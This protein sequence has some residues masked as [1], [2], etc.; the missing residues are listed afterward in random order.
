MNEIGRQQY[1]K[2]AVIVLILVYIGL[3]VAS[4]LVTKLRY[5]PDEPA[6]F[7][8][9]REIGEHLRLPGLSHEET[10]EISLH[11][12]HEAHQPPLYY[13]L[14]AV[15]YFVSRSLGADVNGAWLV[16]RLFTVLLGAGWIYFLYRLSREFLAKGR[17]TAVVAAACVG[18]LPLSTYIGGVVNNDVLISMLFTAGLWLIIRAIRRDEINRKS[19]FQIGIVS[20]LAV[21][22]KSPGLFLLPVIAAAGL[23]IARRRGWKDSIPTLGNAAIAILVA[24]FVSSIWFVR[25]WYV[26]GTFIIQSLHNPLDQSDGLGVT[27]WI[28]VIQLITDQLF[29]Y[30]WTPF[31]LVKDFIDPLLYHSLLMAFCVFVAVGVL[32]HLRGCRCSRSTEP[33][34]RSDAWVLMALPGALIYIFLFRHTLWVDRGALQQGRLLLPAAGIL[35]VAIII[36]FKTLIKRP[37]LKAVVKFS[38][39]LKREQ[40]VNYNVIRM[41][42]D[43]TLSAL[44]I[45][46]L[47]AA[48]LSVLHA[49]AAYYRLN[50]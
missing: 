26:H 33:Y 31:W 37:V 18:L 46:G 38:K 41:K 36:A 4:A 39:L 14:A 5:G 30:F 27:G 11:S 23:I 34:C 50:F 25:N 19:A 17:I 8:Y 43:V 24:V 7:I 29:D 10:H 2:P 48:N 1:H 16:V 3:S 42:V 35:A 15:P 44:L 32:A 45:I 47:L 21:L 40:D 20:G 28:F 12:S 6:H 9:V 13:V 49:I 22:A